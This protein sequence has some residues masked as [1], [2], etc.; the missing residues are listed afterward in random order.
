LRRDGRWREAAEAYRQALGL[1]ANDP[2]RRYL[3]RRLAEVEGLT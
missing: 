3:N 2:E 1:V